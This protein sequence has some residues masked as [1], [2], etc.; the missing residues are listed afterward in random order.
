M[1][2]THAPSGDLIKVIDLLDVTNPS[3]TTIRAR[4]YME[5]ALQRSENFL[6]I[7]LIFPIGEALP[8]CWVDEHYREHVAA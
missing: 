3:A 1:Y 6:K 8:L 5:K 2:L 4:A 7:E